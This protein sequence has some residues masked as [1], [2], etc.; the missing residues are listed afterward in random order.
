M[1]FTLTFSRF[2]MLFVLPAMVIAL[3]LIAN[4]AAFNLHANALSIG[5][6]FD[7]LIAIPLLYFLGIRKT[8]IPNTTTVLVLVGGLVMC[9]F[10]LP[11][12][13]QFLLD[14][15]KYWV[16]PFIELTVLTFAVLK[17]RKGITK[18]KALQITT[19]DFYDQLKSVCTEM[20]PTK[21][22]MPLVTEMAMFYYGLLNWKRHDTLSNEF[23][24]HRSTGSVALFF[25]VMLMIG[26]ETFAFH[27]LLVQSFPV[28]AWV[29]TGLSLYTLLQVLAIAKSLSRR[30]IV[31]LDD[32]VIFRYGIMNQVEV[33]YEDIVSLEQ[34]KREIPKNKTTKRLSPIGQLEGQNMILTVRCPH[35][36]IGIY[37]L[38]KSFTTLLFTVDDPVQFQANFNSK[39]NCVNEAN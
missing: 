20:L 3:C 33:R 37:G 34:S 35:E 30:P 26:V 14:Q 32:R 31:L 10:L 25:A 23:T 29:F 9:T 11:D 8:R 18:F 27:L 7:F 5:I 2:I 21:L 19:V 12:E 39:Y 24:Y 28:F 1:K 13:N 17:V 22:V 36:L 4:S 15:F 16:L 6:T 38:K